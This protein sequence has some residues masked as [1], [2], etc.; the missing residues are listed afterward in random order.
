[1]TALAQPM[2]VSPT[3]ELLRVPALVILISAGI[4]AAYPDS[5]G[6]IVAIWN[7]D[8]F[9]HSYLIPLISLYL[10]WHQRRELAECR[11]QPSWAGLLLVVVAVWVWLV[12][13]Q[14]LLLVAEHLALLMMLHAAVIAGAG[15]QVYGRSAFALGYLA[16]AVPL[17][18]ESV[19]WL[20]ELTAAIAS[21]GLHVLGIPV[22]REEMYF[23]LAG[24]RFEVAEACSGFRYVY[25]GLA[26][27]SLIAYLTLTS[28]RRRIAFVTMAVG[29]FMLINGIRATLI[30]A[31]ASATEM[32]YLAVDHIWF[33]WLLFFLGLMGINLLAHRFADVHR[34]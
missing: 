24:G 1:M 25:S 26:L 22:L 34:T 4:F 33:G 18:V 23:T 29:L 12:A 31:I 5:V 7:S 28:W 8:G 17:G 10:L 16:L 21:Q 20:M 11:L 2:T 13:R 9:Q 32:R 3:A 30:M 14:S 27:S 6:S 15:W 19:P